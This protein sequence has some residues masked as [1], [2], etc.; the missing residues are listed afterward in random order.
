MTR[1]LALQS[2][3]VQNFKAI[4]DSKVLRLGPLT[5]FIGHNGSG[6]SS[7]IGVGKLSGDSVG[8]T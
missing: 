3:R 1:R 4:I 6:K 5:A 2:V 8:W 7:L